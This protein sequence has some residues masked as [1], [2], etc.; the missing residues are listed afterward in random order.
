MCS[1]LPLHPVPDCG[2]VE[3]PWV[4]QTGAGP[5]LPPLLP[6]FARV[7]RDHHVPPAPQEVDAAL[8]LRVE[9]HA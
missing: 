9:G 2:P 3:K 1:R 7:K 8:T 5:A 6:L 4:V